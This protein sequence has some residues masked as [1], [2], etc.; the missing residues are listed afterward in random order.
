MKP[1][2]A[3]WQKFRRGDPLTNQELDS[4]IE[5]SEWGCDFLEARGETGGVLSA[6]RLDLESL[7][8]FKLARKRA[9]MEAW[10]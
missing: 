9:K 7:R 1:N 4:L 5:A 8:G 6:L 10:R 2:E 3:A